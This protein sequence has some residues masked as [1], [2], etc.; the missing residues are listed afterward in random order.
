MSESTFIPNGMLC[1]SGA[2]LGA[3]GAATAYLANAGA[4]ATAP[5]L[6]AQGFPAPVGGRIL[7]NLRVRCPTNP[8][9]AGL[10]ATV[11][12]NGVATALT[13]TVTTGSTALFKDTTHTA[14]LA[15]DDLIDLRLDSTAAGVA[16]ALVIGTIEVT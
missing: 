12:V 1:F 6:A 10:V 13:T 4:I 7:R 3:A 8:L 9:S 5:I 15:A 16:T 11:Y 2:F 14:T